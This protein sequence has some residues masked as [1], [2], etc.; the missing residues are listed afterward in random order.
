MPQVWQQLST[1]KEFIE[2]LKV[3]GGWSRDYWSAE[4]KVEVFSVTHFSEQQ[5]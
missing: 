5:L 2:A 4:M 3:K 1:P